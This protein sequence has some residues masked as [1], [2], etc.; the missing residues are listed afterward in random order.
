MN[1]MAYF[2]ITINKKPNFTGASEKSG[3]PFPILKYFM[4]KIKFSTILCNLSAL[5]FV[6]WVKGFQ[7]D[8]GACL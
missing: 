8:K 4:K 3:S 2:K 7:K 5:L 6:L 1:K